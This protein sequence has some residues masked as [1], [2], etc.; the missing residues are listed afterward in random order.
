MT[1]TPI[2]IHWYSGYTRYDQP[3]RLFWD[4]RWLAIQ[5]VLT[6]AAHPHGARLTV[7]T[8]DQRRFRLDYDAQRD[9]WHGA[10][11]P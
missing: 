6:R 4:G 3:R 7:L 5:A 10:L 2:P 9:R 8:A 11:L 1:A